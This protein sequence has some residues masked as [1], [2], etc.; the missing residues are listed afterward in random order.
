MYDQTPYQIESCIL[1]NEEEK[2]L[3][4]V[5]QVRDDL[6]SLSTDNFAKKYKT[7]FGV[8]ALLSGLFSKECLHTCS[9]DVIMAFSVHWEHYT[10]NESYPVP[11]TDDKWTGS[12]KEYRIDLLNHIENQILLILSS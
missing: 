4:I 10:N 2:I 3:R 5:S 1:N 6:V 8:C 12:G 9:Y 7:K 11:E